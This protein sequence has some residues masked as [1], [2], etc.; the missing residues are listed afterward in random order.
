MGFFRCAACGA[1]NRAETPTAVRCHRCRAPLN[2][3]GAPQSID[4]A[5]LVALL[6]SSPAP[7]LVDF[8]DAGGRSPALEAVARDAAGEVLCLRVDTTREPGA[9]DA[10]AVRRAPAL[11]LFDRGREIGRLPATVAAGELSRWVEEVAGR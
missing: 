8:A 2:R 11:V 5:A 1:I 6:L 9:A 10:Y 4:G 7:V 3:T